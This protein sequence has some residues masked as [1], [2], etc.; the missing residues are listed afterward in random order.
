MSDQDTKDAVEAYNRAI[1]GHALYLNDMFRFKDTPMRLFRTSVRL[2]FVDY[3]WMI[4][5]FLAFIGVTTL[6]RSLFGTM[7]IVL[8]PFVNIVE[9]GIIAWFAGRR[10]AHISPYRRKTGEGTSVWIF[11]QFRGL[12]NRVQ[13]FLPRRIKYNTHR[14]FIN[15]K[16]RDVECVEWIGT[17][18]A[19]SMPDYSSEID[20]KVSHHIL[21]PRG[22][23]K[24]WISKTQ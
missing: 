16:Y 4:V 12:V 18:K 17:M 7:W 14:T 5:L 10:I 21:Y 3:F 19:P 23:A 20:N 6:L 8:D 24:S 13:A 2:G 15:G 9:A 11:Q 22:V 1:N